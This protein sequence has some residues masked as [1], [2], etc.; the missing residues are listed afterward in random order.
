MEATDKKL[1]FETA[2]EQLESI[3]EAMES[4]EI[5]LADLL[6]KFEEGNKLLKI[7]EA[8]LKDAE[9]K[10]ELLKKQKDGVAF[11]SFDAAG[12]A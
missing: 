7:C 10:I 2:L 4:G 9:L 5:P 11:S 3:V 12:D 8:R 6:A 1:S